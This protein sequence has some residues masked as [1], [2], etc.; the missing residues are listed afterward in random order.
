[1]G[2]GSKAVKFIETDTGNKVSRKSTICGSQNIIL[3]GKTI[4]Q[5]SAMIRGDL[6]R[7][8]ASHSMVIAVGPLFR[9]FCPRTKREGK[10]AYRSVLPARRGL[11]DQTAL[12]DV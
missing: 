9:L 2:G 1:M 6:R 12:Q 5:S 8:G 4:I 7:A 10:N 11:R 3:G